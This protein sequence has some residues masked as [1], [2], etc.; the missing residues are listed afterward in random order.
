MSRFAVD[1]AQVAQTSAAVQGS[2]TSVSSEVDRMTRLLA[3]LQTT[4][5]GQAAASFQDVVAQW[6]ATQ[7]R[8]RANLE[9]INRALATAGES[10]AS[11]ESTAVRLFA[12]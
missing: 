2:I 5:Q 7:E 9:D 8:V 1:V 3:D 10:Y 12:S 4:W 6:R 11:A